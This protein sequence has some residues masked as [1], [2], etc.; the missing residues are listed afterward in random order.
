MTGFRKASSEDIASVVSIY[1]KIH[2]EERKG[3]LKIGWLP[4]VYPVENTARAAFE[5][6][7]LFVFEEEK[8][9]WVTARRAILRKPIDRIGY[10]G[11]LKLAL[12]FPEFL[13]RKSTRLNSSHV[14]LSRMPSS[15]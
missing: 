8:E 10:G 15:A 12:D 3:K 13:D 1:Q 4:D 2:E 14:A 5:R 6:Q 7:E 9:N 11:Y